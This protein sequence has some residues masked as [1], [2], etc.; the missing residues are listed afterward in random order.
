MPLTNRRNRA[1]NAFR[2]TRNP[3]TDGLDPGLAQKRTAAAASANPPDRS[4]PTDREKARSSQAGLIRAYIR[5]LS[6]RGNQ[7]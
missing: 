6:T 3:A 7:P 5:Q 2:R 4:Q 1:A